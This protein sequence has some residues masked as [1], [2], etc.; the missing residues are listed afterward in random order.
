METQL[1]LP[2]SVKALPIT[3]HLDASMAMM[4]HMRFLKFAQVEIGAR[5]AKLGN[6]IA[7]KGADC[8][9]AAGIKSSGSEK[10]TLIVYSI[11]QLLPGTLIQY[12]GIM[13]GYLAEPC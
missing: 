12:I 13:T 9:E 2:P 3:L 1:R 11:V 8:K 4:P 6:S 10:V 7:Q 5:I